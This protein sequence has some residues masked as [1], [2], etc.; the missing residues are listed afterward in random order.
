MD[1]C[2]GRTGQR[3]ERFDGPMRETADVLEKG[4]IGING[5][6]YVT[7]TAESLARA[8]KDDTASA[9]FACLDERFV[10]FFPKGGIERVAF[11]GPVQGENQRAFMV[12]AFDKRH[13]GNLLAASEHAVL[14][15]DST[16]ASRIRA[17]D[18]FRSVH[19]KAPRGR[20][21]RELR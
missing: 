8:S 14:P 4:I 17:Q 10:Q 9:L 13:R 6:A 1:Q 18:G 7:A 3:V 19:P 5:L 2:D 11:L 16:S 15:M 12:G 21:H 20:V